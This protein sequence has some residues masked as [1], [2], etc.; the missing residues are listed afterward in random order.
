MNILFKHTFSSLTRDPMQSVIVVISAAMITACVLLCLTI[1]SIF[2]INASLWA[3]YSYGGADMLVVLPHE[4]KA[5]AEGWLSENSDVVSGYVVTGESVVYVLS[6]NDTVHAS[7]MAVSEGELR[8]FDEFTD[9]EVLEYRK[10]SSALPSAHVSRAFA[11]ALS[12]SLGDTFEVKGMGNFC[13][14]AICN[15]TMRYFGNARVAFAVETELSPFQTI[16]FSVKFRSPDRICENGVSELDNCAEA[17]RELLGNRNAV[18]T[19]GAEKLA[20]AALTVQNGKNLLAVAGAVVIVV[21]AC[22]MYTSFSVIVR[23]R[24]NE[25]VKFKAAGATPP[26][27]VLILLAEA[28][29]YALIGGLVGLGIGAVLIARINSLI[30]VT[31]AGNAITATVGDY[32]LAFFIGGMCALAACALPSARMSLRSVRALLGGEERFT[33]M[34]PIP[35]VIVSMCATIAFSV[36]SA[37]APASLRLPLAFTAIVCALICLI[38]TAP[39]LLQAFCALT[40]RMFSKG[41][42]NIAASAA[43]SNA[44]V[45]A[46]FTMLVALVS[47][48][49]LGMSLVDIVGYTGVAAT[50]RYTSDLVAVSTASDMSD[51]EKLDLFLSVDGISDGAAIR[52]LY[53][54][55]FASA[56]GT[57]VDEELFLLAVNSA[58]GLDY[59]TAKPLGENI[60]AEFDEMAA[61][62][63]RPV[64]ISR[65]L[66]EKYGFEVG[67]E[68]TILSSAL[69]NVFGDVFTVAG[70]DDTVTSRDYFAAIYFGDLPDDI[71]QQ[72]TAIFYL[73]GDADLFPAMREMIDSENTTLFKRDGYYPLEDADN[74]DTEGILSVFSAIIYSVAALGLLDLIV[75][76]ANSR[77]REF[78]VLR[79]AG[80]T[81]NN[82]SSYILT[83][84]AILSVG[85]A[86]SGFLFAFFANSA[87]R[88]VAQMVD[89]YL[90]YIPF[91]ARMAA[92]VAIGAGV[93]ALLWALSHALAFRSLARGGYRKRE[94]V[95]LRSD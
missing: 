39:R 37:L 46:S 85:G 48:I 87:S 10:N 80:M 63:K 14:E 18:R 3:N 76:T 30:A 52:F 67:D 75:I 40:K 32:L 20:D 68:L 12:L 61:N 88:G 5:T 62:G 95:R 21:M 9:A 70:V 6:E 41:A 78:D 84:T 69:R 66:A 29:V 57:P 82:A 94:D 54:Y 89:L 81:A 60:L 31:I 58:K 23:A 24:V 42:A 4:G 35:A 65:F 79:L 19:E 36:S 7:V 91:P 11:Q 1:T 55:R 72:S 45:S 15:N 25:L 44:S 16:R 47:F 49:W 22:L 33:K 74:M 92:T 2:E 28:A 64:V 13:V 51:A 26:Q 83:E 27:T 8:H 34:T 90:P 38:L 59:C 43:P 77:R 73:N 71:A 86:A 17:L 53:G 93:F 56:D 50:S